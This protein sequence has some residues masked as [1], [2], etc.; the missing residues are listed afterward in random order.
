M[1]GNSYFNYDLFEEVSVMKTKLFQNMVQ[2]YIR[3]KSDSGGF[4]ILESTMALGIL[5]IGIVGALGLFTHGFRAT[6]TSKHTTEATNIARTKMEEIRNTSFEDITTYY[7]DD[8]GDTVVRRGTTYTWTVSYPDGTETDP[9]EISLVVVW[10]EDS[11]T[12]QV[13]LTT[14]VTSS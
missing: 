2:R 10:Q 6:A 4:T 11:R 8:Y 9:L 1:T 14:L 13:E 7:P 5:L 3:V 12:E